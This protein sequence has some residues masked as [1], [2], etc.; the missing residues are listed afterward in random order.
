MIEKA[1][2]SGGERIRAEG[3]RVESLARI[4]SMDEQTGVRITRAQSGAFEMQFQGKSK[5]ESASLDEK[6]S[7]TEK[8]RHFCSILPSITKELEE[9]LQ[10]YFLRFLFCLQY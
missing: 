2:Q 3:I 4:K 5:G 6:R 9:E 1:F 10:L 7:I 8:A